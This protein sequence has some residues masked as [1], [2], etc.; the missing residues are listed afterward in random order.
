MTQ[1]VVRPFLHVAFHDCRA[2]VISLVT[3]TIP[4]NAAVK[5]NNINRCDS[6]VPSGLFTTLKNSQGKKAQSHTNTVTPLIYVIL[7]FHKFYFM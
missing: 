5:R 3:K 7:D 4:H 2:V 1:Y 6:E